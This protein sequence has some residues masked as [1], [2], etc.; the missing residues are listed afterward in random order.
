MLQYIMIVDT[1]KLVR[2]ITRNIL[3]DF[4]YTVV[5]EAGSGEEA[6]HKY[7]L[8]KPDIIIMNLV[9][10][11]MNTL[12]TI[13]KILNLDS[14]ARIII[15]SSCQEEKEIYKAIKAG[16]KDFLAKPF[17]IDNFNE[18]LNKLV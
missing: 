10:A 13:E 1:S 15:C 2:S 3:E 14:E 7:N 9:M 18:I 12:E 6:I 5:V 4:G 16:A 11:Q 17:N 8:F